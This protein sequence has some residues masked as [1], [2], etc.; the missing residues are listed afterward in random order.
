MEDNT[1]TESEASRPL[2]DD[3]DRTETEVEEADDEVKHLLGPT[4][5]KSGTDRLKLTF[6]PGESYELTFPVLHQDTKH[7]ISNQPF[8]VTPHLVPTQ[9]QG[10]G[11]QNGAETPDLD[12][13]LFQQCSYPSGSTE[14][15]KK[16]LWERKDRVIRLRYSQ[17]DR[18]WDTKKQGETRCWIPSIEY[19]FQHPEQ[20]VVWGQLSISNVRIVRNC[21]LFVANP[22]RKRS[23][24]KLMG[25]D[26]QTGLVTLKTRPCNPRKNYVYKKPKVDKEMKYRL[27]YQG[28]ETCALVLMFTD[29]STIQ[30]V[31]IH[32]L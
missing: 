4:M 19:I 2:D 16:G 28:V 20:D 18:L 22:K 27:T 12:F 32:K 31:T 26:H 24:L 14:E 6:Q 15:M 10:L 5:V 21:K 1:N 11:C 9:D 8:S 25:L 17:G 30:H 13:R 7:M 29:S 23:H 3:P